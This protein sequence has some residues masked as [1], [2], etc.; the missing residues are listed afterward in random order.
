MRTTKT[1]KTVQVPRR[2]MRARESVMIELLAAQMAEDRRCERLERAGV[3]VRGHCIEPLHFVLDLLCVPDGNNDDCD[4]EVFVDRFEEVVGH[5]ASRRQIRAYLRW[6]KAE[7]SRIN[8]V[9]HLC[10]P[11]SEFRTHRVLD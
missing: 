10:E 1:A 11:Q 3:V 6:A 9:A 5:H 8:R 4:R 2:I 7:V